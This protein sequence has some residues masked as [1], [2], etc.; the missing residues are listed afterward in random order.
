[1]ILINK[2]QILIIYAFFFIIIKLFIQKNLNFL[3]IN[4]KFFF[5]FDYYIF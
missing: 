2:T 4:M 3:Q 1:M 5:I